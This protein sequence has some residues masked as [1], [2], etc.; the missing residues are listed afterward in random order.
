MRKTFWVVLIVLG[1]SI[2]GRAV[3]GGEKA[4]GRSR[5]SLGAEIALAKAPGIYGVVDLERGVVEIKGRGTALKTFDI[6]RSKR[7]GKNVGQTTSKVLKKSTLFPPKRKNITPK[8][9]EE[10][11]D[12]ELDVL[13]LSKMP[14]HYSITLEGNIRLKVRP[15]TK[16][17][18]RRIRNF[19]SGILWYAYLP[20]K[21]VWRTVAGKPFAE[22]QIVTGNEKEARWIYWSFFEGLNCLVVD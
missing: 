22:I 7:W 8:P 2:V 4:V 1:A 11:P 10:E 14:T 20:F 6:V 13:E 18:L 16:H 15:K 9:G 21:T 5:A 12:V 17:F 19:G 3:G